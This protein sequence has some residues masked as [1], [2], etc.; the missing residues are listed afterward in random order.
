VAV[1]R[2]VGINAVATYGSSVSEEQMRHLL[3]L[4]EPVLAFDNDTAGKRVSAQVA[5]QMLVRFIEVYEINW[6]KDM[7]DPGDDPDSMGVL[8]DS[9]TNLMAQRL[10]KSLI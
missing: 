6:P 5:D 10:R 4:S 3:T 1:L 8:L 7:K 2:T 9:A